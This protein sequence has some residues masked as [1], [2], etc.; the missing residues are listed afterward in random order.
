MSTTRRI[1]RGDKVILKNDPKT[2]YVVTEKRVSYVVRE[3]TEKERPYST[4]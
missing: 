3:E 1:E 4:E 2:R